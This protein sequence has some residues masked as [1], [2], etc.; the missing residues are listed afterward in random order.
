[1]ALIDFRLYRLALLPAVAAVIVVMF[2]LEGAP[3][4]LEPVTPPTTFEGDRAAA[5][6]RQIADT[7][8][9]RSPG[10]PGDDAVA[11]LVRERFEEI[12]AGAVT[13]QRFE[14]EV[15]GESRELRNVLLTLPGEAASTVLIGSALPSGGGRESVL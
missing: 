5:V 12:P 4:A 2:S 7:A 1:M 8:P 9:E 15:D 14:A 11:D 3:G 10:S 13:E 6:G